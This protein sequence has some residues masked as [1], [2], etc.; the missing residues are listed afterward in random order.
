MAAVY[1]CTKEV[2]VPIDEPITENITNVIKFKTDVSALTTKATLDANAEDTQ[3]L[4]AWEDATDKVALSAMSDSF[5]DEAPATWDANEGVFIASFTSEI[6]TV[7]EDWIYEAVYPYVDGGNIPFGSD[8]TQNGNA[9]NS[10]FDVMYGTQSYSG[11][12]L[13]KDE[14]GE[15]FVIPMDRLTGIAYFHIT[16]GPD[17]DV[18][19]ATL[20]VQSGNIAATSVSVA[21]GAITP[22]EATNSITITFPTEA[23]KASNLQ[24]WFNVLPGSYTGLKLTIV[25]TN[26]VSYLQSKGTMTYT[27]GKINKV[28]LGDLAWLEPAKYEKVTSTAGVTEGKY[29]IVNEAGSVAFDGSLS[30]LD[31]ANNNIAVTITDGIITPTDAIDASQFI[32]ESYDGGFSLQSASGYYV[33]AKA[34]GKEMVTSSTTPVKHTITVSSGVA[35]IKAETSTAGYLKFNSTEPAIT[36]TNVK[37]TELAPC[38][39]HEDGVLWI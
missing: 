31:A 38:R 5:L 25:T 2:E 4:A 6:P 27:A 9:Y 24:L 8:R 32:I 13:G 7:N 33:G 11:T 23:P 26:K 29:L 30:T 37:I 39:R 28:V 34:T 22:T 14:E 36:G 1:S 20:S 16:G 17:E 21:G 19:S 12:R 35:S 10:S 18:V 3:F 15:I